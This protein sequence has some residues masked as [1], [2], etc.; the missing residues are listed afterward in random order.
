MAQVKHLSTRVSEY[1]DFTSI[2]FYK[3]PQEEDRKFTQNRI[4]S[5]VVVQRMARSLRELW[6]QEP[7]LTLSSIR[8]KSVQNPISTGNKDYGLARLH[9]STAESQFKKPI[10]EMSIALAR[11]SG[12]CFWNS[13]FKIASALACSQSG[14]MIRYFSASD[15]EANAQEL[16]REM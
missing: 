4:A 14:S 12:Q 13:L 10:G 8:S 1:L 2:P 5:N 7:L 15:L 6:N 9:S 16:L 3:C 11:I